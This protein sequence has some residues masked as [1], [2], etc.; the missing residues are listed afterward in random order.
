MTIR[1]FNLLADTESNKQS[2]RD[3]M[4]AHRDEWSS[5]GFRSITYMVHESERELILAE[6]DV[7]R[8]DKLV[9]LTTKRGVPFEVVER[10]SRRNMPKSPGEGALLELKAAVD[11]SSAKKEAQEMIDIGVHLLKKQKGLVALFG[12]ETDRVKR[13]KIAAKGVAYSAAAAARFRLARAIVDY[14]PHRPVSIFGIE[15]SD[16]TEEE[17]KWLEENE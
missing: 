4:K 6:L 13:I 16:A 2:N 15:G 10:I 14:A 11:E 5:L 7:R 3:Y 8:C 12:R 1:R 9:E 17:M